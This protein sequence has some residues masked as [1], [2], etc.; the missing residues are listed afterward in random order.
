MTFRIFI[1]KANLAANLSD[2]GD[3]P[4]FVVADRAGVRLVHSVSGGAFVLR[5]DRNGMNGAHAWVETDAPLRV[6]E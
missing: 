5:Y 4:V 3:R 2:G 1:H 6:R